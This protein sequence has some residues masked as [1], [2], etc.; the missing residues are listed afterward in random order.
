MPGAL[1]PM[2]SLKLGGGA[3][4]I[5]YDE[6]GWIAQMQVGEISSEPVFSMARPVNAYTSEMIM[7]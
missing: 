7:R 1:V 5:V 4:F 3:A 2:P 6:E